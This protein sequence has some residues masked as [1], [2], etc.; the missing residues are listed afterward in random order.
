MGRDYTSYADTP[1]N[2]SMTPA[3]R[4]GA[5]RPRGPSPRTLAPSAAT[6]NTEQVAAFGRSGVTHESMKGEH[7]L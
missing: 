1:Q 3:L 5:L 7:T 2:C 6:R 4:L